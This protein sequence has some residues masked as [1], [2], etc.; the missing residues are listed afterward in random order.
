[1][2]L[3]RTK[4][5]A[6]RLLALL[7]GL[8]LGTAACNLGSS[9]APPTLVPRASA[10]PPAT[11]GFDAQ[12]ATPPA[13]VAAGA[14]ARDTAWLGQVAQVDSDRLIIHVDTLQRFFTRH[15]NS[16]K[17]S[18]T[19][20]IGAASQYIE[21][22]FRIIQQAS[23]GRLYTF[24]Q[25]FDLNYQGVATRQKNIAAVLQGTEAGAGAIVIGAHYDS[26]GNPLESGEAFAPGANDNGSGVAALLEMARILSQDQYRA[27]IIFVAFSA[28]EVGRRGSIAFG[29]WLVDNAIDVTAMI[30]IDTIGNIHDRQGNTNSHTLRVYS[31][32][33]NDSSASRHLARM[34]NFIAFNE[35]LDLTLEV[36]NA[37]DREGR[38]GDHFSFSEKGIPAIRFIEANEEKTNADPTDTVEYIEAD[39]LRRT[40]LAIM[41][42]LKGLADG[43]RPPRNVT[44]RPSDASSTLVWEPVAGAAS[45][46]VALRRPGSLIYDQ[47]FEVAE[48]HV[49]WDGFGQYTG[50]AV[51]ARDAA[52][53]VGPL[54]NE[55]SVVA[56]ATSG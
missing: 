42:V 33:P 4:T 53:L 7:I 29:Q 30:N 26:V 55:V 15:V 40:T 43:P 37:I 25:E 48:P 31:Q 44:I 22:Q 5:T 32:G 27:T 20:G 13:F 6:P 38:Y 9:S 12:A 21:E 47:Q 41:T 10:T 36:E 8:A 3:M 23:N 50:V 28:E 16:T 19:Q 39:Y 49:V 11:L 46:I 52:G 35:T 14:E 17:A 2:A 56:L 1:M 34:A 54:S 45:Y 24:Q 51:A 18:S